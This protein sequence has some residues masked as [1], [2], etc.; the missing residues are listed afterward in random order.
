MQ[1]VVERLDLD[2]IVANVDLNAIVQRI[3]IDALVDQTE[4][5][6]LIARSGSAVMGQVI[7]MARSQGVGLDSFVHRWVDRALRRDASTR[8]AGP[9]LLVGPRRAPVG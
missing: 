5:G 4:L 3:D 6:G 7:D 9:P 2:K 8:P 1:A